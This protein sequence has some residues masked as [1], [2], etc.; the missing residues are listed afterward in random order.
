MSI[1][2]GVSL[3][4]PI[5][6]SKNSPSLY[7]PFTCCRR[8]L[9]FLGK[10]E[11][12]CGC[13]KVLHCRQ[14]P[15]CH[16]ICTHW[17]LL[18]LSSLYAAFCACAISWCFSLMISYFK[19][20]SVFSWSMQQFYNLLTC[21]STLWVFYF[22]C[23]HQ[24]MS[25][26]HHIFFF[27]NEIPPNLNM[28]CIPIGPSPVELIFLN[29]VWSAFSHIAYKIW[30]DSKLWKIAVERSELQC[31]TQLHKSV[32]KRVNMSTLCFILT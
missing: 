9:I 8:A 5:W 19:G 14:N 30:G 4:F 27:L 25:S 29:S 11:S 32:R 23:T 13:N 2:T 10:L 18:A 1:Q 6:L 16:I 20:V 7:N 31:N 26:Q 28:H 21:S 12:R 15:L 17:L 3:A 24:N 22:G